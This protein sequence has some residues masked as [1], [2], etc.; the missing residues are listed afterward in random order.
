[1]K[2]ASSSPSTGLRVLLDSAHPAQEILDIFRA[3]GSGYQ[4]YTVV[5][6]DTTAFEDGGTLSI[7]IWVCSADASGS[8]DLFAG[9]V[10]LP[11]EGIPEA[12][13]AAWG[14]KPNTF[15]TIRHRLEHGDIFKAGRHR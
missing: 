9:D 14:I 7:Y 4:D 6:I 5:N 12:L 1:M 8:F 13:V 2:K 3:P 11:K 15:T 10:K